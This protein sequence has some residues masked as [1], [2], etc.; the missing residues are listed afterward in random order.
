MARQASHPLHRVV[1]GGHIVVATDAP[2]SDPRQGRV[3]DWNPL[4]RL[5][6]V[7]ENSMARRAV[8]RTRSRHLLQV[9]KGTRAHG[10][11]QGGLRRAVDVTGRALQRGAI[12]RPVGLVAEA[13]DPEGDFLI[14]VPPVAGPAVAGPRWH[15]G[16]TAIRHITL[17]A[18]G[19]GQGP[20]AFGLSPA[21]SFRRGRAR[22]DDQEQKCRGS[23]PVAAGSQAP[24]ETPAVGVDRV[25]LPHRC[26]A[27]GGRP[28]CSVSSV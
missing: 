28:R 21:P 19:T 9:A 7:L 1:R 11:L 23:G 20:V 5:P 25:C 10:N 4:A 18:V 12:G 16:D 24:V 6:V 22:R 8:R 27:R 17:V 14:G 2:A 3:R 15:C 13:D 26:S